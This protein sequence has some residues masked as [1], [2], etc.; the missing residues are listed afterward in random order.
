MPSTFFLLQF[1]EE[2]LSRYLSTN[3]NRKAHTMKDPLVTFAEYKIAEL[4]KQIA[5]FTGDKNTLGYVSM[6]QDL[7]AAQDFLR[8][9]QIEEGK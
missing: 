9:F 8:S 5:E 7:A 6:K 3:P 1:S 4:K 2:G